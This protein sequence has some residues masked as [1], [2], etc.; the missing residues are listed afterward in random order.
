PWQM[1]SL[2]FG[3]G[4]TDTTG[5]NFVGIPLW[6]MIMGDHT[7]A[8]YRDEDVIRFISKSEEEYQSIINSQQK[9]WG[10]TT[11]KINI[12]KFENEKVVG[13]ME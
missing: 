12:I 10:N 9:T 8:Y 1:G 13:V 4:N 7:K 2:S 5:N 6:G 11:P 3:I